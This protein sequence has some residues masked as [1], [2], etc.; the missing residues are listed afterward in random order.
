MNI[1]IPQQGSPPLIKFAQRAVEDREQTMAKG[2]LVH[3]D[4]DF[5]IVRVAGS[6]DTL[7]QEALIFLKQCEELAQ[8]GKY[9]AAWAKGHRE[10]YQNWKEGIETPQAGFALRTWG[11][12]TAAQ[13]ENCAVA[14][15]FTVEALAA[16]NEETLQKIGMGARALKQKAQAWV[17]AHSG[18]VSEEL[19]NLRQQVESLTAL[20]K[21]LQQEKL[22]MDARL[23]ALETAQGFVATAAQEPPKKAK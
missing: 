9:P 16:A 13:A 20:N 3:K 2:S 14:G 6:K 18:N 11:V 15:V 10:H 23:R 19:S 22:A 5:A 4:V 17:D 8:K 7:E 21:D 1:Q 12:I